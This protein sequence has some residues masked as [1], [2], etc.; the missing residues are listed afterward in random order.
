MEI[1]VSQYGELDAEERA[2]DKET[3]VFRT[4]SG[5]IDLVNEVLTLVTKN[6]AECRLM[7]FCNDHLSYAIIFP[8]KEEYI[9][10]ERLLTED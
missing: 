10:I 2:Y 1:W 7:D 4:M 9:S 8:N 6:G 5:A 3:R